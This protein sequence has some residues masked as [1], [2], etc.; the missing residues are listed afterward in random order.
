MSRWR[1]WGSPTDIAFSSCGHVCAHFGSVKELDSN[2]FF[3]WPSK[4][5]ERV[6][7]ALRRRIQQVACFTTTVG[8]GSTN[9]QRSALGA[10]RW[11]KYSQPDFPTLMRTFIGK[12]QK[13]L[14]SLHA[15]KFD[16]RPVLLHRKR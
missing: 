4:M 10:D 7:H 8:R 2:E 9:R 14:F 11:K 5:C 16:E 13:L 1:K 6:C 12:S 15:F 3:T